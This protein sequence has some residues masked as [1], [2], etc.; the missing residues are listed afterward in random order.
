[1]NVDKVASE[2]GVAKMDGLS[3]IIEQTFSVGE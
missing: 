1:M 2:I 3:E